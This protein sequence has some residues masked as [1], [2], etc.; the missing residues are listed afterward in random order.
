[1]FPYW[2]LL[3]VLAFAS[4]LKRS[5]SVMLGE[6]RIV[7]RPLRTDLPLVSA[8]LLILVMVGLRYKVGGDWDVYFQQ[9]SMVASSSDP[10]GRLN[11]ETG[12]TI[13]NWFAGQFGLGFWFVNF[14]CAIP[15][16]AGLILLAHQQRNPWL[17]LVVATPVFIV[18]IGMGVIVWG[19]WQG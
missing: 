2:G 10:I 18:L 9:Y 17:A 13:L 15:F 8:A 19:S 11:S 12:Y 16:V 6:G 4:L 7:L 3:T 1:M 14:V 5:S